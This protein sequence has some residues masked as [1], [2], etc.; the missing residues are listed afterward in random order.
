MQTADMPDHKT[1]PAPVTD[2]E[3]QRL[4]EQLRFAPET[5]HI[6]L[7]DQR[8]LLM[9]GFSLAAMR[10]E[11]IERTGHDTARGM[12][13]RLG[14]QQGLEDRRRLSDAFDDEVETA[15]RLGPRLRDIQGYVRTA[16]QHFHMNPARGEFYGEFTWRNSWEAEAHLR[17]FGRSGKPVCW[18][19]TGYASAFGTSA[20]GKPV[21]ARETHCIGMGHAECRIVMQQIDSLPADADDDLRFLQVE[22]FVDLPLSLIHI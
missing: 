16:I 7:F 6:L 4:A 17:H 14:Y 11:L 20:F 19:N 22:D 2:Q 21:L 3:R 18:M 9:H 10:R 5:G 15:V 1:P 13:T 12:F 8:M